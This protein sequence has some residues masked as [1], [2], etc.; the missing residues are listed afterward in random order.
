MKY[1]HRVVLS[2]LVNLEIHKRSRDRSSTIN[3]SDDRREIQREVTIYITNDDRACDDAWGGAKKS[4]T[5][6]ERSVSKNNYNLDRIK[7]LISR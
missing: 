4:R 3:N 2:K 7:S 5:L 6:N 1:T